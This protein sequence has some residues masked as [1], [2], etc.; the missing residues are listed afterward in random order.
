MA[1][2]TDKWRKKRSNFSTTLS[3]SINAADT[4]IGLTSATGLP[5]DTAITLTID[6]VDSNSVSTPSLRERV[7]GVI[8][9]NNITNALRGRDNTTAQTHDS[10][11]VVE[12]IWDASTWNDA[13]DSFLVE[14]TQAGAHTTDSIAEKTSGVG[15]TVDGTLLKDGGITLATAGTFKVGSSFTGILDANGNELMT[16]G[17]TAS[18][19]NEM[20]VTNA[21]TGNN[22][23]QQVTGGDSNV[24]LDV[25]MKG[26]GRFRKPTIVE[27]PAFSP[28]S[29]TATGDGKAG[30]RVPA[31]LNG[32]DLTGISACVTT[33][34]TTNTT[35][36]QIRR[37]RAAASA[38]MLSTKATIDS[39]EVDTS[40]AATPAVIN[41]SNDDVATGDQIYVDVDA[42]STTAAKGLI[43]ELRFELP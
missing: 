41:T 15:V 11:A 19:V 39:T 14:H 32:M 3:G 31:E 4:T 12:D 13:I 5:T 43:V 1:A 22:V 34:G 28:T 38:D 16:F 8:S 30:F 27:I 9:S 37:V 35:D 17:Q 33:A 42:V 24:G 2:N 36:V 23:I 6:R 18:A 40:T 26:S 29:D 7:T 20:K 10:G 25:K 21:A